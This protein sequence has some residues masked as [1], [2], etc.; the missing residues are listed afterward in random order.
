MSGIPHQAC[1]DARHPATHGGAPLQSGMCL[2]SQMGGLTQAWGSGIP[3]SLVRNP[4]SGVPHASQRRP[5]RQARRSGRPRAAAVARG[6]DSEHNHSA[7]EDPRKLPGMGRER[8]AARI[9]FARFD[10]EHSP[11][12]LRDSEAPPAVAV[13]LVTTRARSAGYG[14]GIG[15]WLV[16]AKGSQLVTARGSNGGV[17]S[18]GLRW[19]VEEGT[20]GGG[21]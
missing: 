2:S 4:S 20:G 3:A 19:P 12:T 13:P 6:R 1:A 17:D 15:S 14:P 5:G 9:E 16:A 11:R 8:R 18:D 7:G 21:G 10:P